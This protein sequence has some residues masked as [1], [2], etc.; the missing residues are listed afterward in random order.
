MPLDHP[1]L[2]LLAEPQR[3]GFSLR[4]GMWVRLIDVRAARSARSL[5]PQGSVVIEVAADF[6]PWDAGRWWIGCDGVKRTEDASALLC[7]V[8]ALG[9]VYLGAF[10]MDS[11]HARVAS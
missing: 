10:F 11:A 7:D 8:T 3:L 2:L 4:D 6:C 9:S 1:L 5:R